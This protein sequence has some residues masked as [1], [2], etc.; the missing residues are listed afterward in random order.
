[1]NAEARDISTVY[2]E[3]AS[4]DQK[5]ELHLN[6]RK[7]TNH[8]FSSPKGRSGPGLATSPTFGFGGQFPAPPPPPSAYHNNHISHSISPFNQSSNRNSRIPTGV[9]PSAKSFES[10]HPFASSVA[11]PPHRSK[12]ASLRGKASKAGAA[13]GEP[14]FAPPPVRPPFVTYRCQPNLTD[15]F[16]PDPEYLTADMAVPRGIVSTEIEAEDLCPICVLDLSYEYKMAG[17]KANVM[18]QCGHAMHWVSLCIAASNRLE[19]P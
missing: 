10:F 15:L 16:K 4:F 7:Q 18:P 19:D 1:M 12:S 17:E 9:T 11:A 6:Q 8:I 5:Q 3:E 13:R 14:T 2:E